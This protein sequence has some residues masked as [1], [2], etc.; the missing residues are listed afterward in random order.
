[1]NKLLKLPFLTFLIAILPLLSVN[2]QTGCELPATDDIFVNTITNDFIDIHWVPVPGAV[3]YQVQ[4]VDYQ[5]QEIIYLETIP[6]PFLTKAM[7]LPNELIIVISTSGCPEGPF[8][9]GAIMGWPPNTLVL[10]DLPLELHTHDPNQNNTGN[11]VICAQRI[12]PNAS[13]LTINGS[14]YTVNVPLATTNDVVKVFALHASSGDQAC[15]A[16]QKGKNLKGVLNESINVSY[17]GIIPL[18]A[19]DNNQNVIYTA[20][21]TTGNPITTR[22]GN[23]QIPTKDVDLSFQQWGSDD[24]QITTQQCWEGHVAGSHNASLQ[25]DETPLHDDVLY[26]G[27]KETTRTEQEDSSPLNV[28]PNPVQDRM[29]LTLPDSG[30]VQIA[31]LAGRIW[32]QTAAVAG[33]YEL[34][35]AQWAKGLYILRFSSEKGQQSLKFIKQ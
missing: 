11:S 27:N 1:M 33:V 21:H 5:T 29:T 24:I 26:L 7:E 15:L 10:D 6:E 22:S 14:T 17:S 9:R 25:S 19:N 35:L 28:F 12:T 16:V 31:D 32:H 23:A 34:D 20:V 3:A 2:G 8:G 30:T 18:S 4:I 13:Q